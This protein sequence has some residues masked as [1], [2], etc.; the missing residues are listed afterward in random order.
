MEVLRSVYNDLEI[1][2]QRGVWEFV[3]LPRSMSNLQCSLPTAHQTIRS[4]SWLTVCRKTYRYLAPPEVPK[5]ISLPA[6]GETQATVA[7]RARASLKPEVEGLLD[8]PQ[9]SDLLSTL[10]LR[11]AGSLA[12]QNGSSMSFLL[13]CPSTRSSRNTMKVSQSSSCVRSSSR[14]LI[15]TRHIKKRPYQEAS[16]A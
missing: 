4:C 10:S 16:S 8:H 12:L 2:F 3:Y 1:C 11:T 5:G 14:E 13:P 6:S 9:L 15:H 7:M